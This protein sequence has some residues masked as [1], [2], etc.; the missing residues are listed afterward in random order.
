[1]MTREQKLEVQLGVI[2][3]MYDRVHRERNALKLNFKWL[4]NNLHNYGSAT[5]RAFFEAAARDAEE[6]G[7]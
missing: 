6:C 2:T 5:W 7:S 4:K 3:E 1:M